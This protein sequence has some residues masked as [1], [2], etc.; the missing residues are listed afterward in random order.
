MLTMLKIFRIHWSALD[1]IL[2]D[3]YEDMVGRI[4]TRK[5]EPDL[6]LISGLIENNE[7]LVQVNYLFIWRHAFHVSLSHALT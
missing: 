4:W 5:G 7:P 1:M 3:F 6:G 2:K